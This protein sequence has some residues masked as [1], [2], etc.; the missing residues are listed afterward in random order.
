MEFKIQC[1]K[2]GSLKHRNIP[3]IVAFP[4]CQQRGQA[5][6]KTV[7]ICPTETKIFL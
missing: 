4:M 7:Y 5:R 3:S 2:Q 6:A 1:L